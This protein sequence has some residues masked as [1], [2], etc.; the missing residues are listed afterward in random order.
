MKTMWVDTV[1]LNQSWLI[2]IDIPFYFFPCDHGNESYNLIGSKRGPD[3]PIDHGDSNACVIF[4]REVFFR[5]R[6]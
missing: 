5:L 3:F 2:L 1:V 4:F 6:A